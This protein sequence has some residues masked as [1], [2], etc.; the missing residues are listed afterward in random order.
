MT[1]PEKMRHLAD[2]LYGEDAGYDTTT[3]RLFALLV[4]AA[5]AYAH[6]TGGSIG[7]TLQ[8]VGE[9]LELDPDL[10]D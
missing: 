8:A 4:D 7:A 5:A 10:H 1:I 9:N 6:S 2:A 3:Q